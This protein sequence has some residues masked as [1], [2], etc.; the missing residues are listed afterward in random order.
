MILNEKIIRSTDRSMISSGISSIYPE[1]FGK[2]LP[3]N[4]IKTVSVEATF[5]FRRITPLSSPE[6]SFLSVPVADLES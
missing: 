3:R 1:S 2:I 5:L 4:Q 6:Q